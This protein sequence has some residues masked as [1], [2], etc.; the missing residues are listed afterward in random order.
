[1]CGDTLRGGV[2][3]EFDGRDAGV[4]DA[5]CGVADCRRRGEVAEAEGVGLVDCGDG[6]SFG[7]F[8]GL[9]LRGCC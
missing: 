4:V 3:D 1:V 6:E 9:C 8:G 2:V 7:D 5:G